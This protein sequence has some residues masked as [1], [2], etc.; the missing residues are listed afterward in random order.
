LA[1]ISNFLITAVRA[2]FFLAVIFLCQM[3]VKNAQVRIAVGGAE[4]GR[5]QAGFQGFAF[6]ADVAP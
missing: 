3:L 5:I 6:T 1:A 4:S 2:V